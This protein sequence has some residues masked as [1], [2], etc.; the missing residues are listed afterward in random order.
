MSSTSSLDDEF[1]IYRARALSGGNMV[2]VLQFRD[3]NNQH[4]GLLSTESLKRRQTHPAGNESSETDDDDDDGDGG[5][6]SRS[7][8]KCQAAAKPHCRHLD[9]KST[10]GLRPP[11]PMR[12][13]SL[14]PGYPVTGSGS[15][16]GLGSG[17]AK[18]KSRVRTKADQL[19]H[20]LKH[21]HDNKAEPAAV[22]PT[23]KNMSPQHHKK[24]AKIRSFDID[25]SFPQPYTEQQDDDDSSGSP[26]PR[27]ENDTNHL[28]GI[29]SR[30]SFKHSHSH[31]SGHSWDLGEM[32][33]RVSSMPCDSV[34]ERPLYQKATSVN[35]FHR[36]REFQLTSKGNVINKGSYLSQSNTSIESASTTASA[37]SL[38]EGPYYVYLM[39]V[40]GVGV[41]AIISTFVSEDFDS[42]GEWIST[43]NSWTL[44]YPDDSVAFWFDHNFRKGSNVQSWKGCLAWPWF[45]TTRLLCMCSYRYKMF[46]VRFCFQFHHHSRKGVNIEKLDSMEPNY[47]LERDCS[48]CSCSCSKN[49]TLPFAIFSIWSPS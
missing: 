40:V 10:A 29:T 12:S 48:W 28:P 9:A 32:R 33:P 25:I 4:V 26:T 45:E 19:K 36:I 39:G 8:E 6:L 17:S 35:S 20:L 18:T 7:C 34:M 37:T 5:R 31:N 14:S 49:N 1:E 11:R 16:P 46:S 21:N 47:A 24:V 30:P 44:I 15:S 22:V 42:S 2:S 13:R 3:N 27:R 38:L 43:L 23:N 41:R